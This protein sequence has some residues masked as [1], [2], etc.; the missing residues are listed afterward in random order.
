ML[1]RFKSKA[2]AEIVMYEDHA[3]LL[4]DLFKKDHKRGVF[5]AA[6][7]KDAITKL[8]AMIA[9]SKA[10]P[11]SEDLRRDIHAHHGDDGDDN[12]HETKE[13]VDLAT[14][15]FPLLEMLRAAHHGGHDILWG[16]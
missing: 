8:E 5:T 2:A 11:T 14:H 16:V 7:C 3:K 12:D 6:E 10:H 9:E 4:L 13:D 1:V 15:A